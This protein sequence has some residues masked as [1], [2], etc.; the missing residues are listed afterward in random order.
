LRAGDF[1]V[2]ERNVAVS[3]AVACLEATARASETARGRRCRRGAKVEGSDCDEVGAH[4]LALIGLMLP[5]D[6][7]LFYDFVH[8]SAQAATPIDHDGL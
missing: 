3:D 1:L 5:C 6:L 7:V 2:G 8:M 4:G